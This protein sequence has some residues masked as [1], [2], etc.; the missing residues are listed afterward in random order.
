MERSKVVALH[1]LLMAQTL[2]HAFGRPVQEVFTSLMWEGRDRT[3]D[4][5]LRQRERGG[6]ATWRDASC[7][8]YGHQR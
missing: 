2:A 1:Y 5:G 7:R 6:H 3:G 4:L 8:N